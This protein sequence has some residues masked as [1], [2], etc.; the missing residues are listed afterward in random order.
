M[1]TPHITILMPYFEEW[2]SL[3]VLLND[4][5]VHVKNFKLLIVDDGSINHPLDKQNLLAAHSDC[6]LL[7]LENN[8][9]HQKAICSGLRYLDT[10]DLDCAAI[11]IMDSDGEDSVEGVNALIDHMNELSSENFEYAAI[12][13]KRGLRRETRI[14]QLSYQLFKFTFRV[15]TG[16]QLNF[17]NFMLLSRK[18]SIRLSSDP[19]ADI[20]VAASVLA[21]R[22]PTYRVTVDKASRLYGT[23]KMNFSKLILHGLNALYVFRE[24]VFVRMISASAVVLLFVICSSLLAFGMKIAGLTTPGWLSLVLGFSAIVA[25][26][27]ITTLLAIFLAKR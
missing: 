15:F 3:R 13:A 12:V 19:E 8:V 1:A 10:I 26:Q 2:E 14:F 4:L 27:I 21:S 20:H 7:R 24:L 5:K 6:H 17:G 9:G 23:S 16:H 18:A 22:I 25:I 11:V